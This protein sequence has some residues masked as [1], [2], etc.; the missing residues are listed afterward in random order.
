[1]FN[2]KERLICIIE[3]SEIF[4]M[5]SAIFKPNMYSG[6]YEDLDPFKTPIDLF[7]TDPSKRQRYKLMKFSDVLESEVK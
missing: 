6:I 5:V 1:M 4:R 7:E 3:G 2:H